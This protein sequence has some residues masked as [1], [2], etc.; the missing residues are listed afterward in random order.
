MGGAQ[1]RCETTRTFRKRTRGRRHQTTRLVGA[2]GRTANS[3]E[4][5]IRIVVNGHSEACLLET[6]SKVTLLS[7]KVVPPVVMWEPYDSIVR[8][9]NMLGSVTLSAKIRGV[10]LELPGLVIPHVENILIGEEFMQ[11]IGLI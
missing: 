10:I 9:A 4:I 11:E 3:R 7:E 6:G 5:Y 2:G 1:P 8:A